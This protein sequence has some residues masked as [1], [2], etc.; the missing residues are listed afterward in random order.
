MMKLMAYSGAFPL[1][2]WPCA[3]AKGARGNVI[4]TVQGINLW[5]FILIEKSKNCHGEPRRTMTC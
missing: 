2:R 4:Y 1:A 3:S 5:V